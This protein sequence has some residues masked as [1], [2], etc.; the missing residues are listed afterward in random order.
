MTS[1]AWADSRTLGLGVAGP[2]VAPR[3]DFSLPLTLTNNRTDTALTITGATV[4]ESGM[5]M[6]ITRLPAA[7]DAGGQA[8]ATITGQAPAEAAEPVAFTVR[9]SYEYAIVPE[10]CDREPSPS[11]ADPSASPAP[12]SCPR[13][14]HK[15]TTEIT[16]S[17]TL[18][19][20]APSPEP[21]EPS[22]PPPPSTS[23]PPPPSDKPTTTPPT[24][25][26][27]SSSAPTARPSTPANRPSSPGIRR[28]A[29]PHSPV[30]TTRSDAADDRFGLPTGNAQL[31]DLTAPGESGADSGP[32]D[33]PLVSPGEDE[34]AATTVAQESQDLRG[35]ITP[36]ILLMFL[37]LLLLLSAPLAPARR[38]RVG[39]AYTG[40]RRRK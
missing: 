3:A 27:P 17:V 32:L 35:S 40:K 11:P 14:Q 18:R 36:S 39:G 9:V 5:G 21:S 1:P 38:V 2:T 6:N 7:L 13:E 24:S 33:L 8:P 20:P 10:D 34:E 22:T 16:R 30:S 15:G 28:P 25:N 4:T 31:P 23:P 12:E 37:L 26:P 29:A 19:K